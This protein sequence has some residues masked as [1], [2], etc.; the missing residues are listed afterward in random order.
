MFKCGHPLV[1]TLKIKHAPIGTGSAFADYLYGSTPD[2][3]KKL[4]GHREPSDEPDG[5]VP[6]P[7]H[8]VNDRS[9]SRALRIFHF[10]S[11]RSLRCRSITRS[12]DPGCQFACLF[13]NT[14]EYARN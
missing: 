14:P 4:S 7:A 8:R 12:L 6:L 10:S 1:D 9:G 13:A 11:Y 2:K 3:K 5:Y